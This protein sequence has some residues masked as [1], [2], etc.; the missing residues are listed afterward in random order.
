MPDYRYSVRT[1]VSCQI[2]HV[3]LIAHDRLC[4]D[5][6]LAMY[7]ARHALRSSVPIVVKSA[8]NAFENVFCTPVCIVAPNHGGVQVFSAVIKC[9]SLRRPRNIY[10]YACYNA[11]SVCT[12]VKPSTK[13]KKLCFIIIIFHYYL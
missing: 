12:N 7:S 8:V 9:Y 3:Q 11:S 4:F 5:V 6:T 2:V 1:M 13:G 10:L